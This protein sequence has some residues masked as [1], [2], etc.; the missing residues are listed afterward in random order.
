M[1]YAERNDLVPMG[2]VGFKRASVHDIEDPE[3]KTLKQ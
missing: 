3:E 1:G 2:R